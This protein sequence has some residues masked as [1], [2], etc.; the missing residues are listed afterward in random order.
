MFYGKL[1][2]KTSVTPNKWSNYL[3]V[4]ICVETGFG[5]DTIRTNVFDKSD[6]EK[7]E[8]L[9]IGS[10]VRF[11]GN[12]IELSHARYF[13]LH[14]IEAT[15]FDQ[16]NKCLA[17]AEEPCSGCLK[18]PI[19]R[20]S[21]VWQLRECLLLNNSYKLTF[22]QGDN[23]LCRYIF[24]HTPFHVK[25]ADFQENDMV[26]LEGWRDFQRHAKFSLIEKQ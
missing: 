6:I 19:E 22:T 10:Q 25:C 26:R 24:P 5:L 13:R 15:S 14:T 18:D 9:S 7:V 11:S 20:I 8:K 16:C 3:R 2:E 4:V 1:I 23:T 12:S 17:P 21:G